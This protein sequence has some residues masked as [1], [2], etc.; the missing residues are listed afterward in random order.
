MEYPYD[1][2]VVIEPPDGSSPPLLGTARVEG[3]D[4]LELEL[5][6]VLTHDCSAIV[7]R[8]P[9]ARDTFRKEHARPAT[10]AECILLFGT[11]GG[12]FAFHT[13]E[14]RRMRG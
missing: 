2:L 11:I 1:S 12:A 3:P 5:N 4:F 14:E 8:I 6:A 13:A 7:E 10:E 9:C